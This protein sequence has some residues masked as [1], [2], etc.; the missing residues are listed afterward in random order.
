VSG[1]VGIVNIDGEPVDALLVSRLT[2]S[3][4]FRGPDAQRA[5]TILN[6]GFGYT[7]LQL[8]D[9]AEAVPQPFEDEAGRWIVGDVRLDGRETLV[10]ELAATQGERPNSRCSDAELILSAYAAWGDD[11]A[12][13]LRGDFMFAIWDAPR[14]RLFCA[15]DQ[16]GVKPFFYAR[17]GRT[18]LFSNLVQTVALHPAVSRELHEPAI[19]DFLLFGVNHDTAS[20]SFRDIRRLP[21]AHALTWTRDHLSI[22]RYW[23][24]PVDEPLELARPADYPARFAELL[25]EA[26]RDRV[27]TRHT[28]VLMSGGI[29]SATLAAA[30]RSVLHQD[31]RAGTLRA[32]TSVYERVVPDDERKYAGL[33]AEHLRIPIEYDVRDDELSIADLDRLSVRTPEPVANPA[34]FAAGVRFFARAAAHARVLLYGEGPD[35]ALRYEW[36]AYLAHL[37]GRRK[38]SALARAA[39]QD[40]ALHRRMPLWSSIRRIPV[41]LT[42][43]SR[44]EGYPPWLAADFETRCGCR[45]RWTARHGRPERPHPVRPRAHQSFADPRW[46]QLFESCDLT[47]AW[48]RTEVRHPYLD[49]R[50]LRFLL[51]VPVM[52]WCRNKLLIRRAMQTTLPAAVLRRS[53]TAL[54]LDPDFERARAGGLPRLEPTSSFAQFVNPA[55]I[56]ATARTPVELRAILRAYGLNHWLRGLDG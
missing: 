37:L 2:R 34:A 46:Q 3:L 50:V 28:G 10:G 55:R 21:A 49:L 32:L 47:G 5:R 8:A 6:A 4:T 9:G 38:L 39:A 1:V 11:C 51:A 25:R 54:P 40:L 23:T 27:R 16:L 52:P 7:S 13:R 36:R 29:D 35:N 31:G 43:S 24:L 22:R 14:R 42:T 26:V 30:A 19:A 44:P 41:T 17:F 48:T 18:I 45:E 56:P 12:G 33:V 15:R 20:T 53:K